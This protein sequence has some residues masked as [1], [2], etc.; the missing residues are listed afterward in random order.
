VL[1]NNTDNTKPFKYSDKAHPLGKYAQSKYEAEKKLLE[2][3]A[4]TSLE[5][6]IIR[7]PIVYGRGA[8]GIG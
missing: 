2:I 6:I 3:N 8:K 4:K 5:V 7:P 1:G